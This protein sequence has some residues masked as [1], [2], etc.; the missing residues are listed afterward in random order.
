MKV[1]QVSAVLLQ[2]CILATATAL[3]GQEAERPLRPVHTYSIVARDSTSGQLGV[4]VQSHWF[5]VGSIVSWAAPGVG[6]VATQSFAEVSY[7]PLGL[8]LMAAGKSAEQ[9]LAALLAAD[10][11]TDVRQV[12][13]IDAG[14]NV[15]AHTGEHAIIE[16]CHRK[17][18]GYSVQANLMLRSTVCDAMAR[19]FES[20]EGDLAEKMVSAMEAAQAE[21][22]D[23]RGR[24]SAA[25]LVVTDDASL[26]A[27]GGR[28]F[29]LRI[30]DHPAPLDEMRRLLTVARAYGYM[31][32][33][34]EYMTQ[35]EVELA[36]EA[37]SR[38]EALAPDNHE[39]V[40]WHA[41]T[42]AAAGRVDESLPLFKRSFDMWPLWRELVPR[43]PASG[44]LPDDPELIE[45]IV[46]VR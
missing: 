15:A 36:V 3:Q 22:G 43:L 6:A 13:M 8:E 32:E 19:A 33:G 23:I 40:F 46:G 2:A 27:W 11:H 28:L 9:A 4:A 12:A 35:G 45:R 44:L 38:A 1:R 20:A 39:M 34:D 21:G 37:Y 14:G 29:D 17:G 26:P 10:D 42:L 7:G 24:Q 5:S 25:L 30:E 31:N 18:D 16:H 41:A